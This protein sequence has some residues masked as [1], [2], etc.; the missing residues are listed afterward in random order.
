MRKF[1]WFTI[2]FAAVSFLCAWQYG[3]WIFPAAAIALF[4]S[5]VLAALEKKH[6]IL[7]RPFFLAIGC[8]I[9]MLWFGIYDGIFLVV[10]RI[11]DGQTAI[12][13]I[14]ASDYAVPTDYG[15]SIEGN[16]SL[17]EREYRVKAY[18]NDQVE[19]KPGD[20]IS[21]LFRFR[22]TADGGK[23]NPTSHRSE[24]IFLL[25]YQT[26]DAD[27]FFTDE[28]PL[29]YYPAQWRRDILQRLDMCFTGDAAAF[30]KALLLGERSDISYELNTAFQISGISHII[31]VSGLHV[32]ILFGLIHT[33]TL[34]KKY[35]TFILGICALFLFAAV[36]GFT[37]SITRA[38]IMQSL[39]LIAMLT[40]R[41]YD[42]ET[43]LAFAVFVM[44]ALNPMTVLSVSF[45][46]SV[47]CMVG[48][49]L[50]SERIKNALSRN[51]GREQKPKNHFPLRLK[52]WLI[53]SISVTVGASILT[54][55]LVAYYFGCV[56]LVGIVTNLLVL[57]V[58]SFVFS[59]LI[60]CLMLSL[61]SISAASFFA[62]I[63]SLPIYYVIAIARLISNVPMAAVYTV[64]I[65]TVIWLVGAYLMI[66]VFLLQKKKRPLLLLC[67][68]VLTILLSQTL[69]WIEPQLDECRVTVLDVGQG[70]CIVLQSEGR[71]FLVDCGGDDAKES[72]DIAAATL[73]SS[74]ISRLD[75]II[76]THYDK[77]HS[78]GLPY[79]LKRIKTDRLI[80]PCIE[81]PSGVADTLRSL[82]DAQV[83]YIKQDI[84]YTFGD[85]KLT[86]IGPISYYAGNES[87]LCVLFQS[88]NCDILITGDREELGEMMLL[89]ERSLPKLEL[90]VVGHHGASGAAGE[91]LLSA[92]N[93]QTAIISVGLN[94]RYNHPSNHVLRRLDAVGCV[95]YRTDLFGTVIFRR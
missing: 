11:A 52:N 91:A 25:A 85:A 47:G 45:Q 49:F 21:G 41:E 31:A 13:T 86:V 57:W 48:I 17:G 69:S 4:I 33:L 20:K 22:L 42:R 38:S 77:D 40:N 18:L 58:I 62:S 70:Q 87:S 16:V 90:L 53:T 3:N 9:G 27:Y 67:S 80:L 68:L 66:A 46:L 1:V 92:T 76:L 63:V 54:T 23:N 64:R 14:E 30:T 36:A 32:S 51:K 81:D 72:A 61:I 71:T 55:P 60:I 88:P 89:H 83:D 5:G 8:A 82:T 29:R 15:V 44:L 26:D 28:C 78:G 94:N 50:F 34:K 2:G 39:M 79:L 84:T 59:A 73:L 6:T 65:Y 12:V 74:G 93:P 43:A 35:F 24:G 7:K 95:V 10:P 37:P 19:L 75:G 56:S